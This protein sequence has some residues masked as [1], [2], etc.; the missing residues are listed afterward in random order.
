MLWLTYIGV[1]CRLK[2][3]LTAW[4]VTIIFVD[5]GLHSTVTAL[6]TSHQYLCVA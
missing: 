4:T 3:L 1:I 2:Y 5:L 6:F